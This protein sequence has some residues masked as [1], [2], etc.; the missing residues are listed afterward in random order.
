MVEIFVSTDQV[1]SCQ[2]EWTHPY[3]RQVSAKYSTR[4]SEVKIF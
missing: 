3:K 1:L 2:L 4:N